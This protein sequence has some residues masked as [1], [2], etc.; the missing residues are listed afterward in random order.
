M[1]ENIKEQDQKKLKNNLLDRY[2]SN[3]IK[4]L[5]KDAKEYKSVSPTAILYQRIFMIIVDIIMWGIIAVFVYVWWKTRGTTKIINCQDISPQMCN[6]CFVYGQD[7]VTKNLTNYTQEI[8][9]KLN[10]TT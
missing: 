4:K 1:E 10:F 6:Q 7:L 2:K 8:I 3:V 5:E 9:N